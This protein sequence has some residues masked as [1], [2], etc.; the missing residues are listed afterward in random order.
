MTDK[1]IE[2]IKT[3]LYYP[4][5]SW[6]K[7]MHNIITNFRNKFVSCVSI[8]KSKDFYDVPIINKLTMDVIKELEN[9]K[10]LEA[11]KFNEIFR[12]TEGLLTMLPSHIKYIQ[13]PK[14]LCKMQ[15][16]LALDLNNLPSS[17]IYLNLGNFYN[18]PIDFLPV[19]LKY[20]NLGSEF[21]QPIDNLPVDLEV[22][23]IGNSFNQSL[24]N[25]PDS[26]RVIHINKIP[27]HYCIYIQPINRL[28]TNL[29]VLILEGVMDSVIL[30]IDFASCKKL[31]Y[32][33]LR[34]LQSPELFA[35][36][37]EWSASL[38]ILHL[39]IEFNEKIDRLPPGLDT[40]VVG[41]DFNLES[42]LPKKE[43]MPSSLKWIRVDI[44][45]KY[46]SNDSCNLSVFER[47]R[48]FFGGIK[49]KILHY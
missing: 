18:E 14:I 29:E 44:R 16:D 42:N 7:N 3:L 13:L 1:G 41:Q 15:P 19:G 39:G 43:N 49:V 9:N 36:G 10:E 20:L 27:L 11:I 8:E 6:E 30:N 25:L 5:M 31:W 28:P 4:S 40:L 45:G 32:L 23:V 38:K 33:A 21:N 34:S 12:D 35:S 48:L 26:I 37:R 47:I 22:L 46:V 17:L 2:V 24:D